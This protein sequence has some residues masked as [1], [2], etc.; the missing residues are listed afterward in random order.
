MHTNPIASDGIVGVHGT[1][2][3]LAIPGQTRFAGYEIDA[4]VL[5]RDEIDVD[6]DRR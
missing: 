3:M 1:P 4:R 6:E 5:G 2:Y